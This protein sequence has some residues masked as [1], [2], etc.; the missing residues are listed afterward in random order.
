M[1]ECDCP[2]TNSIVSSLDAKWT[3][4]DLVMTVSDVKVSWSITDEHEEPCVEDVE[5]TRW[6]GAKTRNSEVVVWYEAEAKVLT[7]VV[8]C[9]MS[10]ACDIALSSW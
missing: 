1:E 4:I 6:S 8:A 9:D 7:D 2:C 5:I 10:T 3:W